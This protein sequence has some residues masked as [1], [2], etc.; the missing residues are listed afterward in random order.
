[1]DELMEEMIQETPEPSGDVYGF[2]GAFFI[3]PRYMQQVDSATSG[4]DANPGNSGPDDAHPERH[5]A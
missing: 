4:D 2:Y 1:M 5:D 3:S